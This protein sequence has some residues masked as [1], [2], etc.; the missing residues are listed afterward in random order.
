MKPC[1][2]AIIG[3]GPYGLSIAAHLR[4][5][6]MNFRIFGNPMHTWRAQMPKG[7]RLK[8]EG[9]ASSLDDP[10]ST[11]TLAAYCKEKGLPYAD[12]GIPVPLETFAAYGLEFQ[13][14]FVPNLE[15]KLVVLLR[16]TGG[17]YEI[18]LEN[19]EVVAARKVIVA[20]GLNYYEYVPPIL[21]SLPKTAISHS[22]RYGA[23]DHLKG[24]EIAMVGAGASAMDLAALLHQAGARVQVI[25]RQ[26]V[27]H[28]FA[29]PR[30]TGPTLIERLRPMTGLGRG[31]KLS[32]CVNAPLI[33][34]KMPE[35]LRI[36]AVRR[37]LGPQSSWY[38][39]QEVVGKMPLHTGHSITSATVQ[40]GRV[41][42]DLAAA[43]ASRTI[44]VDHVIAATGYRVDLR[45]LV[46]LDPD[47]L[48]KI[49]ST[50]H[51]PVLSANFESSLAG[52]YFVGTS[53]VN[54]FGPLMRFAF[55]ARF[56]ARRLAK[57]LAR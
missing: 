41:R 20:A 11:L 35:H 12:T 36:K 37:I 25:A 18:R 27:I 29:P 43:G 47:D 17:G 16:R 39:K 23:I 24:R 19:E 8:S 31:W 54:T 9:F 33:F 51:T 40:N 22:A 4:A 14:R 50:E 44:E 48:A 34:R 6:G 1:D 56:T 55:G 53:A 46:F 30:P 13:K 49:R 3:A 10:G 15:E 26:P 28:F 7:M 45:R 2:I 42:L 32:F 57:H 5:R 52:L 38:I 21:S